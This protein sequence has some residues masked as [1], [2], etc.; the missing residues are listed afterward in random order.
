MILRIRSLGILIAIA[1]GIGC[2]PSEVGPPEASETKVSEAAAKA[3]AESAAPPLVPASPR[4]D[5]VE[6]LTEDPLGGHVG[7][8]YL[9]SLDTIV[10]KRFLRVLT[11]RNA[12]DFFLFRGERGGY[13]YEMVKDFTR[14]LSRKLIRGRGELAI[15]FELIPVDDDQLIPMLRAGSA[16]MIAA[17]MTITPDR[18][19]LVRFTH[20]YRR[21]DE[22][23]VTHDGTPPIENIEDLSGKIVVVRESSSY[24]ESLTR[25]NLELA[26][27]GHA[28]VKI[29]IVDGRLETERILELVAAKRFPYTVADSMIAEVAA[30]TR[31]GLRIVEG[32][33]L[34]SKGELAWATHFGALTLEAE[35]NSFLDRYQQGSL[36][37]NVTAQK[38]FKAESKLAERLATEDA[39]GISDFDD[40]FKQH[41][42]P[43]S[44]DWRLVAAMAYQ[45][46]RFDPT[47]A[48]RS[49]AVGLLQIKPTTAREPYVGV[50]EVEGVELAS[51]NVRAGLLYLNWIKNRYFDSVPEMEEQDRLRMSL[52][53][54]NA[55]PRRLINARIRARKLGLDPNRWFRHVELALV[56]MRLS[57]PV[58]YVSEINQ[59]YLAYILL[60]IE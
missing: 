28:P 11:S 55:G 9:T 47:A 53:A 15:Q 30:A 25:L 60:G 41:A 2:G 19:Q 27:A 29:K 20:P 12:F 35:M 50:P 51:E 3:R 24:H 52:A 6:L 57:E 13:Q 23:L 59:R 49:G 16:D 48:N 44:I 34:R 26:A 39:S 21:V 54:Y 18:A 45:E 38:Y 37:G 46:S 7:D 36:L 5:P 40:L 1:A 8:R 32:I 43:F 56:D 42:A 17:R 4:I 14:Y 58:R 10:E 22:L 31:P 33:K